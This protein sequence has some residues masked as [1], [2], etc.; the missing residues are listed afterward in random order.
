MSGQGANLQG[1]SGRAVESPTN[2]IRK[3]RSKEM[4]GGKVRIHPTKMIYSIPSH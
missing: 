4:G 3:E 1:L 2:M